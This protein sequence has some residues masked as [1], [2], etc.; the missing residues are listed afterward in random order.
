MTDGLKRCCRCHESKPFQDFQRN[1]TK[2]DGFQSECIVCSS[3]RRKPTDESRRRDRARYALDPVGRSPTKAQRMS[4]DLKRYYGITMADFER[5]HAEQNGLCAIC[6]TPPTKG[7]RLC[8]D[9][10]HVTGAVRGLLCTSCNQGIGLLLDAP[11]VLRNAAAYL[12]S[13]TV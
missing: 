5:L 8:V 6:Q 12:E 7:R 11:Q 13:H 9:H 10:S 3:I 4:S 2:R 1:R